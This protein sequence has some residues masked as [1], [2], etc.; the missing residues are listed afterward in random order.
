MPA[1][2]TSQGRPYSVGSQCP[3]GQCTAADV[4]A[5]RGY[6]T[7]AVAGL[8]RMSL[9]GDKSQQSD[10]QIAYCEI[11]DGYYAAAV[12]NDADP[13]IDLKGKAWTWAMVAQAAIAKLERYGARPAYTNPTF[14]RTPQTLRPEP[15]RGDQIPADDSWIGPGSILGEA[16]NTLDDVMKTSG[17]L[18]KR[19]DALLGRFESILPMLVIGYGLMQVS[20]ALSIARNVSGLFGGGRR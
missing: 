7:Q 18:I 5:W 17:Q 11:V 6:A 1:Q 9:Q 2:F 15:C 8:Y 14:E 20:S 13:A 19:A 3:T 16:A 10:L 12:A 4:S